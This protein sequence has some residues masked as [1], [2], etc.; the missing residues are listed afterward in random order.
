MFLF[1]LS[2]CLTLSY[3][4]IIEVPEDLCVS[5]SKLSSLESSD[6]EDSDA[7]TSNIPGQSSRRSASDSGPKVSFDSLINFV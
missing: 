3:V 6:E 7:E 4:Q 5:P 2:S 1:T